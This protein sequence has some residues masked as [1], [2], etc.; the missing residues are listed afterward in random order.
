MSVLILIV[1]NLLLIPAVG[2]LAATGGRDR[3]AWMIGCLFVTSPVALA[4]LLLKGPE[5]V[6]AA[7]DYVD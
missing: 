1:A 7:K 2:H 5:R 6:P 3:G 4:L